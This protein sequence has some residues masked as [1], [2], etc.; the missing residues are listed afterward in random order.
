MTATK[1]SRS[2]QGEADY[3]DE[4]HLHLARY[5]DEQKKA[6]DIVL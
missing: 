3:I 2:T 5:K 6:K 4:L 1:L